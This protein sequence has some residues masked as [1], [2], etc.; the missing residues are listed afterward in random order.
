MATSRRER[1]PVGIAVTTFGGLLAAFATLLLSGRYEPIELMWVGEQSAAAP[2][3]E[4]QYGPGVVMEGNAG[5]DGAYFWAAADQLPDIDAAAAYLD[6][7]PY[8]LQRILPSLL[9][10]LAG[11]GDGS[12]LMLILLSIAGAA[13]CCGAVADLCRR[14]GRAPE[15]GWLA[16]VPLGWSI[17]YSTGE[18]LAFALGFLGLAMADRDR[19]G[20][21]VVLISLGTL[22]RE[23][24]FVFGLGIAL[25]LVVAHLAGRRRAHPLV[26]GAYV[27]P[28]VVDLSWAAWL[29]SRYDS[30]EVIDR[31]V[32]FGILDASA[33]GLVLGA[34]IIALGVAGAWLWRDADVAWGVAL[35][36]AAGVLLYY[37]PLF[38]PR[39]VIRVSAPAITLGLTGLVAAAQR[40]R[41]RS[42]PEPSSA[43]PRAP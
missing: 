24:V 32:P 13:T 9:A 1:S 10:S 29:R 14:H 19:H 43:T 34:V 36:F 41:H 12:A 4:E 30:R 11:G 7:A 5:Y 27:V 15:L 31:I 33:G 37:G 6:D 2:L 40:S 22:A 8:R 21:A 39:A 35:G 23:S 38:I 16:I 18:P 20:L 17:F 25:G 26:I 42:G 28:L 3:V